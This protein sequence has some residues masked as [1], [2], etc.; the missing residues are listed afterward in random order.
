MH[1]GANWR[2]SLQKRERYCNSMRNKLL[3]TG[4]SGFLGWNVCR[5]AAQRYDVY[6]VCFQHECTLRNVT[7]IHCDLTDASAVETLF[8]QIQPDAVIHTA[9]AAD[10]NYCQQHEEE[11]KKINIEAPIAIARH[12]AR[13]AIPYVFTSSDLVFDGTAP[14]YSEEA[15]VSPVS[16]YGK[17]KVAAEQGIVTA[18]P[19]AVICRMPLMYGDA[20]SSARSFIHPIIAALNNGNELFLFTDEYRTPL[21]AEDAASGLLLACES[22]GEVPILHLGGL[23]RLSRYD[24]GSLIADIL[25][26]QT[27]ITGCKQKEVPM[28]A[29]RPAD[30]SLDSTKAF[31]LGFSPG[32]MRENLKI[33]DCIKKV[34]G[35]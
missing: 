31:S 3:V 18:H 2:K 10:P 22:E 13:R 24:I 27:N 35:K 14:P 6:G 23:E 34:I 28:T 32:T 25:N 7:A 15:A 26:T 11:T 21:S 16:T 29:P 12:C 17:Q 5:Y 4:S 8:S 1:S 20:P 9:A 19:K 30:V 33:L